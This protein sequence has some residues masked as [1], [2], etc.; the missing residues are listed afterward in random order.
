MFGPEL[1]KERDCPSCSA[2]AD[3]VRMASPSAP[4]GPTG[5]RRALR[6]VSR[7]AA[8]ETA[9]V[10]AADGVGVSLGVLVRQR[11]QFRLQY[12]V[13]RAAAARPADAE[14]NYR[15][16]RHAMDA[17]Q[18]PPPVARVR[19]QLR[20]RLRPPS[21]RDRPGLSA[22]A[23]EDGVV[24]RTLFHLCPRAGQASGACTSGSTAPP[25]AATRPGPGGAATTS[26][27]RTEPR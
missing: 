6:A 12:L 19:G 1:H 14:Y 24:Y 11:L 4:G 7:R 23:R 2:I 21:R 15:R 26:T 17:A 9:G 8:R 16:G 10:Q 20:N 27:G 5:H 13:H 3:G 18:V 22:F 25:G